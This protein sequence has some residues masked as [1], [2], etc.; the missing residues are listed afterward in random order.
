MRGDLRPQLRGFLGNWPRNGTAL[1][2]TLV[3][4]DNSGIVLAVDV[5]AI[6]PPP[7]SPLADDDGW[8]QFL[9]DLVVTLLAGAH[10]HIADGASW[11]TVETASDGHN[12]NDEQ[13][14]G[15]RVVGA[16]H[17]GCHGEASGDP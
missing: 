16:V 4:D 9:P 15:S 17:C 14:L 5:S 10:D 7:R 3:V 1:G 13:V 12:C 11:K 6:R 8:V 2:L